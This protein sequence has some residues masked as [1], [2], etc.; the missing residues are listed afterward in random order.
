MRILFIFGT[1]PEA[2]K[3]APLIL[4]LA[5]RPESFQVQVCATGQHREMLDQV[6]D[7]F[8]IRPEFDLRLMRPAQSLFDVSA[9]ALR[10]LEAVFEQAAPEHVIVQGDAS[11]AFLGALAAYYRKV[12]VSHVEAGLRSGDKYSPFP[13]EVNRK[14]VGQIADLH[15]A[16][17]ERA[18][19]SLAREG[20]VDRVWVVG[21][22]VIDALL[23]GLELLRKEPVR[24]AR[25]FG[26][27]EPGARVVLITAHRRESFGAPFQ[28][29]V[30][31]IRRAAR[32]FSEVRFVFPVHLNPNVQ[33][34]VAAALGDLDNVHLIPPLEYP[35]LLWLMD[36]CDVVL[37]D[38]GGIQEEAPSL[39]KPVLVMRDV[40]ERVEGVEAGTA[41]LVGTDEERIAAELARLLE[42]REAY[43]RMARAV[44]PYG[45]GQTSE[46][47][48]QVLLEER[49]WLREG[50]KRAG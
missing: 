26:F 31:A 27:L 49:E 29:M 6:L 9:E 48:A 24:G 11:S 40:T 15:F 20:V 38:S 2:I 18:R 5:R 16:P 42:D 14:L 34:P 12:S 3:L 1:R 39:G 50:P 23:L 28:R 35:E 41:M 7:F 30:R 37:T 17:T 44:N 46:R 45:D 19:A 32:R 22:T 33:E 43:E 10:G 47:I 4:A 8:G 21:N 13:E 36:R 25:R